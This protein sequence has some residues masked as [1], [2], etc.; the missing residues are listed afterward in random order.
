LIRLALAVV[1]LGTQAWAASRSEPNPEQR[2]RQA[3]IEARVA[4]KT[5]QD[6]Y[7]QKG[8]L[9]QTN[10]ALDQMARSVQLA[11]DSLLATH[12]NPSRSPK[13]FKRAEIATREMLRRLDDFRERMNF[14]DRAGL[15]KVRAA[16]QKV[17]DSLLQ[18]IM[19]GKKK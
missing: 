5:A 4:L 7:L 19:G 8:D 10:D 16:I 15:D 3:L 17:H 1:L 12:K 18:G 2:A 11:Y 6:A 9:Q 13:H 14:E